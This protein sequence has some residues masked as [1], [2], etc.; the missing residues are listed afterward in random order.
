MYH[1]KYTIHCSLC[2]LVQDKRHNPSVFV[3]SQISH[4]RQNAI[5]HFETVSFL[6]SMPTE[7][8]GCSTPSGVSE[9]RAPLGSLLALSNRSR[10][11]RIWLRMR[12]SR[13]SS[14]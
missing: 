13:S 1:S 12:R 11:M 3:K 8:T 14:C 10:S 7:A 4:S 9:E 5:H 2:L 6:L